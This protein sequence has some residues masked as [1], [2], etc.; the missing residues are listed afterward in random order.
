MALPPLTHHEIL[1]LVGPFTR[2]GRRV[3]LEAS[4]RIARKLR[5]KPVEHAGDVT[6]REDLE[7]EHPW[8]G[9]YRLTR[10]LTPTSGLAA[11][12]VVEGPDASALLP[13]VEA[14]TPAQQF[15]QGDGFTMAYSHLVDQNEHGKDAPAL[16]TKAVAQVGHLTA[17]VA[18]PVVKGLAAEVAL[19]DTT[20]ESIDLP[21]DLLAVIGWD[22]APLIET[23]EG[24]RTKVRL[25]GSGLKHTRSAQMKIEKT[26]EHLARTLSDPPA[27]FHERFVT[28]RWWSAVR[29]SIPVLTCLAIIGAALAMPGESIRENNF[30]VM[31]FMNL[32]LLIIG[33]SFTLQEGSRIEVPAPPRRSKAPSWRRARSQPLP[34]PA[35]AEG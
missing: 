12:L 9:T 24:W 8:R 7:L 34:A 18:M 17:T 4:D 20:K 19:V 30:P 31:A 26:V 22:W 32:P 6:L 23:D 1:E 5:F 35:S 13:V 25:R 21:D 3:D 11:T 10:T 2:A 28:A 27:R 16:L 14:V 29:R 15:R 33:L